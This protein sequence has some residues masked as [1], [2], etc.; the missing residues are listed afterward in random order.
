[1]KVQIIKIGNSKGIR[2]PKPVLTQCGFKD[3]LE[4]EVKDKKM[5]ISSPKITRSGWEKKFR[6]LTL[7]ANDTLLED[8]KNVQNSFDQNEWEW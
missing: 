7:D 2:I 3:V 5:V 1:M 6:K 8:F 4:M